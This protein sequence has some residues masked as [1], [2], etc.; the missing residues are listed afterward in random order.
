[1]AFCA[2]LNAVKLSKVIAKGGMITYQSEI[3]NYIV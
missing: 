3:M 1:M 2:L